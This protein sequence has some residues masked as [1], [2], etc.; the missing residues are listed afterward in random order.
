MNERRRSLRT[1]IRKQAKV[2]LSAGS[3]SG[4]V[5]VKYLHGR[6]AA[7][8]P[9][10]Q[11]MPRRLAKKLNVGVSKSRSGYKSGARPSRAVIEIQ[12]AAPTHY[13]LGKSFAGGMGSIKGRSSL[14]CG[15]GGFSTGYGLP[16]TSGGGLLGLTGSVGMTC[17][18]W[19]RGVVPSH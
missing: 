15:S 7:S 17:K 10:H 16:G 19:R 4:C 14:G 9:V 3:V 8:F 12:V 1:T 2:Q 18:L 11:T 13:I 5:A 6:S